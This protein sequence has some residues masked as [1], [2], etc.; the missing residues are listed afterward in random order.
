MFYSDTL[1]LVTLLIFLLDSLKKMPIHLNVV[2]LIF[3]GLITE[4]SH[5]EWPVTNSLVKQMINRNTNHKYFNHKNCQNRLKNI[6]T[7]SQYS[8][9]NWIQF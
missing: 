8:H 3:I 6:K 5:W 7:S 1:T 2:N 4:H 9:R